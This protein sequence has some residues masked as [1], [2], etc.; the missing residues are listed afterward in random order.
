[1]RLLWYDCFDT[2][3]RNFNANYLEGNYVRQDLIT[4]GLQTNETQ[5]FLASERT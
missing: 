3:L 4:L 1:M 2:F 5:D